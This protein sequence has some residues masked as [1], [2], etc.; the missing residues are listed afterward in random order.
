VEAFLQ[1][2]ISYTGI[3][4]VVEDTLQANISGDETELGGIL[5]VD[6]ET[7]RVATGLI[8]KESSYTKASAG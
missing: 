5:A 4:S 8:G 2:Q 3:C 1:K 6:K 7:R